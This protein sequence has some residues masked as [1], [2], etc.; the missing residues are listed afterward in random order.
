MFAYG[1]SYCTPPGQILATGLSQTNA[2]DQTWEYNWCIYLDVESEPEL[3]SIVSKVEKVEKEYLQIQSAL[4]NL[5]DRVNYQVKYI[6][7]IYLHHTRR[8]LIFSA[9]VAFRTT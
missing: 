9:F 3:R 2:I 8:L 4:S 6:K 5:K 1:A 7:S